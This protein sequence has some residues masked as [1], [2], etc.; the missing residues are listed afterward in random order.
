MY[1]F[2]APFASSMLEF[3]IIGSSNGLLYLIDSLFPEHTYLYN[4][5]KRE[6]FEIPIKHENCGQIFIHGFGFDPFGCDYKVVKIS[7]F[8]DKYTHHLKDEYR[9]L[10]R[11][12]PSKPNWQC[13]KRLIV[14]YNLVDDTTDEMACPCSDINYMFDR[15][16]INHLAVLDKR[17]CAS[18]PMI[19][20]DAFDVWVMREYGV[21][22]SWVKEYSICINFPRSLVR[23]IE[24]THHIWR[25]R[26]GKKMV[27]VLGI[28]E[29]GEVIL[30][31]EGERLAAYD[32][33]NKSFK[34][35]K[36]KVMPRMYQAMFHI[37]SLVS[38]HLVYSMLNT[39]HLVNS[40]I[41]LNG[42]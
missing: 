22:E 1:K 16:I 38:P 30:E 14:S 24:R 7:Y 39:P 20:C 11:H 17:L 32:T 29:S 9:G 4:P 2:E 42:L 13:H 23:H 26:F 5:F 40:N 28:F 41:V 3:S 35:L 33:C 8:R 25:N 21:D 6:I 12:L 19:D 31:Y 27:K 34:E 36:N 18:V 15:W 37:D 10:I